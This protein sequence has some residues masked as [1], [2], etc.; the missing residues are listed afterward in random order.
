MVD[1]KGVFAVFREWMGREPA[2]WE[3]RAGAD[4]SVPGDFRYRLGRD[5]IPVYAN[6]IANVGALKLVRWEIGEETRGY[7]YMLLT[8]A[9]IA[10][11]FERDIIFWN[12]PMD[13][14]DFGFLM[15]FC[16]IVSAGSY[17]CFDMRHVK[18]GDAPVVMFS[19]AEA[20]PDHEIEI[21]GSFLEWLDRIVKYGEP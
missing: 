12:R 17:Y 15:P 8:P 14:I 6:F 1:D 13:D 20:F 16:E 18:G 5:L 19:M 7:G 9:E 21:C 3:L 4:I 11:R 10:A 2:E